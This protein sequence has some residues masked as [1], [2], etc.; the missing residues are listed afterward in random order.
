MSF[1]LVAV[2]CQQ[3]G[4]VVALGNGRRLAAQ[5][6]HPRTV[7]EV[8]QL[9]GVSPV[10]AIP[11][12]LLLHGSKRL[13]RRCPGTIARG[14]T[15]LFL[16]MHIHNSIVVYMIPQFNADGLLPLGVHWPTGTS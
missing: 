6:P 15:E 14:S 1:H 7:E 10:A 11:A 3:A 16:T 4:P 12:A 5:G 2:P 9:A 8:G 13:A